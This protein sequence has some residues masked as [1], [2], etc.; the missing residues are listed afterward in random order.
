MKKAIVSVV[1][2]LASVTSFA[3]FKDDPTESFW[4]KD[5]QTTQTT[6]KWEIVED[7]SSRCQQESKKRGYGGF[8][9]KVYACSFWERGL[10]GHSCTIYT[11]KYT[12]MHQIGH[13]I[14][15]CF[16]GNFH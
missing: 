12:T 7:A 14:R 8:K 16:Q 1:L 11:N 4:L 15:H 10:S 5:M 2:M 6:V 9:N 3:G 13:E